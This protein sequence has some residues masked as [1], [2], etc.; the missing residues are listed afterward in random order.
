[1]L[2]TFIFDLDG[3]TVDSSHRLG[4]GSLEYWRTHNTPENI[5]QDSPLPLAEQLK[6]AI[7]DGLDCVILT[8]RV[9]GRADYAW[10]ERHGMK[11]PLILNRAPTDDRPAG[12]YKLARLRELA[13]ARRM[14]W[15]DIRDSVVL[16]DDDADVKITLRGAGV[17]VIDPVQYNFRNK[18]NI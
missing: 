14:T 8:S 7:A 15:A 11:A 13:K 17:R 10:L 16:W 5:R 4:D 1:M 6:Q 12:E 2:N 18:G 3:T 9:M